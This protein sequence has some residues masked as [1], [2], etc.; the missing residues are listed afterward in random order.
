MREVDRLM[1]ERYRIEL[2][3]MMENAG[4]NL[5]HLAR[6][7]FLD[8]DPRG[9]RLAVLCGRGGNGGGGLVAARRLYNW[10]AEIEVVVARPKREFNGVPAHQLDIVQRLGVPILAADDLTGS[11]APVPDLVIDAVI[12]YGLRGSPRGGAVALIEW[13]NRIESPVLSLDA[14]SGLDTSSGR[15]GR[16]TVEATATMTLALPKE[17]L[18]AATASGLVGELYLA[19]I[20]VPPS[21]YAAPGLELEV[22]PLFARE[23]V[24]RLR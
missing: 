15:P 3:Q 10:G 20:S 5:A 2:I 23:E 21:L 4:R 11:P 1:I 9:K 16:P 13:A 24:L 8:G 14:P 6:A 17:G 7:R 18:S 19:D 12:G 22:P